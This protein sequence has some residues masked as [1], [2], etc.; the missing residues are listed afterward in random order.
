MK[1]NQWLI[2]LDAAQPFDAILVASGIYTDTDTGT[3]GYVV[4]LTKTVTLRGGYDASFTDPPD[5]VGNPTVLDA[6]RQ[7]R[8]ISITGDVIPTIEGFIVT[9]GNAYGLGGHEWGNEAGGGIYCYQA[10]PVIVGNVITNNVASSNS[11]VDGGG[12]YLGRC[13]RAVVSGNTIVSNTASIGGFGRGG[14]V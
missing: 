11:G 9:G 14:E 7:G 13:H 4:A 2:A 12:I 10:H 6:Q 3:L 8:V 5:P 1:S